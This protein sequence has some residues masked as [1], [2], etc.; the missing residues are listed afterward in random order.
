[1][2]SLEIIGNKLQAGTEMIK[3]S[4]LVRI[5]RMPKYLKHA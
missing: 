5:E 4:P 1:L 3:A 2:E